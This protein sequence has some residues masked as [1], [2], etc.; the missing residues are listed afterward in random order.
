MKKAVLAAPTYHFYR[1]GVLLASFSGAMP[2]RIVELL[3]AHKGDAR[4]RTQNPRFSRR[5]LTHA[6]AAVR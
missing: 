1:A 4:V 5:K 6:F 3:D 2:S